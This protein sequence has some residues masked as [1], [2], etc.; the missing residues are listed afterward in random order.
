MI[1]SN[2]PT[3]QMATQ[4]SGERLSHG[5]RIHLISRDR[6][7]DA[8]PINHEGLRRITAARITAARLAAAGQP[9]P[10]NSS[11]SIQRHRYA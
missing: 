3:R 4:V 10:M 11:V 5:T 6:H 1:G 9:S 8:M 7:D 2:H